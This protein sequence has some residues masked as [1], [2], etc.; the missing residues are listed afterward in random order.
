MDKSVQNIK[1]YLIHNG[2]EE[3]RK[4]MT[5][6]FNKCG[7]DP[8]DVKWMI[9]PNKHEITEDLINNVVYQIPC[10][11]NNRFVYPSRMILRR[12]LIS[13]IY[14]HYLALKDIVENGYDYGIIMEDNAMFLGNIPELVNKYIDQLQNYYGGNWDIVFDSSWTRYIERPTHPELLVYP[15]SNE[16]THQ[17]HGGTKTAMFYLLTNSCAKKLYENYL[18][19]YDSPDWYMNDLFRKLDIKSFW[20][21]PPNIKVH[22]EHKS[23]VNDIDNIEKC[24]S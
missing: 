1:Y 10:Q 9:Y 14:K 17:C 21:E 16:I 3:R 19:F 22:T 5:D 15:K 20:V 12:G 11:S 7:I 6:Q 23:S 4:I 24:K 18:P 8:Q 2:T 13:C